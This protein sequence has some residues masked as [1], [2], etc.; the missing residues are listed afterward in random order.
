MCPFLNLGKSGVS[1]DEAVNLYK[2]IKDNLKCLDVQGVMEI[3]SGD[4]DY[5]QGQSNPDFDCLL[6]I[7][8]KILAENPQLNPVLFTVSMG[9]SNDFE[10]A[11]GVP[12]L[13]LF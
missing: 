1:P 12:D 2:H 3:G 5:S 7:R 9:M 10:E 8:E 6:D 4:F 11:V 13:L